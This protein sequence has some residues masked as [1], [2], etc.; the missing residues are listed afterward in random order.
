MKPVLKINLR[1]YFKALQAAIG[2]QMWFITS[3]IKSGE[4]EIVACSN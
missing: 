3:R 4:Y 1:V 2:V